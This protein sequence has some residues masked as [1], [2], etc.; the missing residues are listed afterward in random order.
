LGIGEKNE[1]DNSIDNVFKTQLGNFMKKIFICFICLQCIIFSGYFVEIQKAIS[2]NNINEDSILSGIIMIVIS[3]NEKMYGFQLELPD[4]VIKKVFQEEVTNQHLYNGELYPI[5]NEK[6]YKFIKAVEQES[7]LKY[8]YNLK[9]KLI[10]ILSLYDLTPLKKM[11]IEAKQIANS[12][13]FGRLKKNDQKLTKENNIDEINIDR[14]IPNKQLTYT[15]YNPFKFISFLE[16]GIMIDLKTMELSN[17]FCGCNVD[18]F[19]WSPNGQMIAYACAD[20]EHGNAKELKVIEAG[21]NNT[22]FRKKFKRVIAD[23]VWD[24]N[25]KYIVVL[26]ASSILSFWPW[27]L[28]HTIAGHPESYCSFYLELYD[29]KGNQIY[30]EKLIRNIKCGSSG[31]VWI[32]GE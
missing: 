1:R 4:Y 14:Y 5:G 28:L 26:N 31:L 16:Y 13:P 6:Y 19:E 20:S 32:Y 25:S 9:D 3:D 15:I 24:G 17:P 21:N 7:M 30:E 2:S 22:I 29:L 12:K 23:F 11:Y 8:R 18:D 27:D 10:Q